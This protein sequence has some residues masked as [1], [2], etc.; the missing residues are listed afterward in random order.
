MAYSDSLFGGQLTPARRPPARLSR[1]SSDYYSTDHSN[2]V[3]SHVQYLNDYPQQQQEE[4][5]RDRSQVSLSASSTQQRQPQG[6]R[7]VFRHKQV[8]KPQFL[9]RPRS[10]PGGSQPNEG[11]IRERQSGSDN[12]RLAGSPRSKL[13]VRKHEMSSRQF[14]QDQPQQQ[15]Q[16]PPV[17]N[18]FTTAQLEELERRLGLTNNSVP[19]NS[20]AYQE[21]DQVYHETEDQTGTNHIVL[22]NNQNQIP[23]NLNQNPGKLQPNDSNVYSTESLD[24]GLHR[25]WQLKPQ[26]KQQPYMQSIRGISLSS[27]TGLLSSTSGVPLNTGSGV[28]VVEQELQKMAHK[29]TASSSDTLYLSTPPPEVNATGVAKTNTNNNKNHSMG[30]SSGLPSVRLRDTDETRP[31]A[32]SRIIANQSGPATSRSIDLHARESRATDSRAIDDFP[33]NTAQEAIKNGIRV[34][35][36]PTNTASEVGIQVDINNEAGLKSSNFGVRKDVT[37]QSVRED[38][39]Q[40]QQEQAHA[41]QQNQPEEEKQDQENGMAYVSDNITAGLRYVPELHVDVGSREEGALSNHSSDYDNKNNNSI[42]DSNINLEALQIELDGVKKIVKLLQDRI[43]LQDINIEPKEQ[44]QSAST[45]IS[46]NDN[47]STFNSTISRSNANENNVNTLPKNTNDKPEKDGIKAVHR[48]KSIERKN[49]TEGAK[50]QSEL[51]QVSK[52]INNNEVKF[53]RPRK[54]RRVHEL[55]QTEP[56]VENSLDSDMQTPQG[57]ASL[58]ASTAISNTFKEEKASIKTIPNTSTTPSTTTQV[59]SRLGELKRRICQIVLRP[60]MFLTRRLFTRMIIYSVVGY[61]LCW[62]YLFLVDYTRMTS[63]PF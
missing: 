4:Y 14:E 41:Q 28:E 46:S 20:S 62:F 60:R 37:N 55:R 49:Y 54:P 18:F 31:V 25:Q 6:H 9:G 13:F 16:L 36:Q 57:P 50:F 58:I 23:N 35:P 21:Q 8:Y 7:L 59:S 56:V 40:E 12:M 44:P 53:D 22:D 15:Q 24:Q 63:T 33:Q 39:A 52:K 48:Q 34:S 26:Q 10:I 38:Q 27:A 51:S 1:G 19:L 3:N 30:G 5:Y 2:N 32:Y 45:N 11:A 42:N 29:N 17:K 47:N 61:G 43:S